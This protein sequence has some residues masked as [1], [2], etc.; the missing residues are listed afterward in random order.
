MKTRNQKLTLLKGL[1]KGNRSIKEIL[2]QRNIVI[3]QVEEQLG[4]Y[5][6][7]ATGQIWIPE[8]IKTFKNSDKKDFLIILNID[9]TGNEFAIRKTLNSMKMTKRCYD[10]I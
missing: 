7:T 2:P 6:E 9:K 5:L 4:D 8:R 1:V 10:S 3:V